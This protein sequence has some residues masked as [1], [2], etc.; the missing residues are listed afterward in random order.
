M[1]P[2]ARKLSGDGQKR[3]IAKDEM[4]E[5]M[6]AEETRRGW[7]RGE[8]GGEARVEEA[9]VE[10]ARVEE[11]RVVEAMVVEARVITSVQ[12]KGNKAVRQQ[13]SLSC[14]GLQA[15]VDCVPVGAEVAHR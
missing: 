6:I 12:S 8:G 11:A 15:A 2:R 7:R 4:A 14:L 3:R 10:E 9:R 5:E 1:V 13:G